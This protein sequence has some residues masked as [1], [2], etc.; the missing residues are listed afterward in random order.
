[1]KITKAKTKHPNANRKVLKQH[2]FRDPRRTKKRKA[3]GL[4]TIEPQLQAD[5][6]TRRERFERELKLRER[7]LSPLG[8]LMS[9]SSREAIDQLRKLEETSRSKI[10]IFDTFAKGFTP[11]M[12]PLAFWTQPGST[13]VYPPLDD[14]WTYRQ[15]NAGTTA[16][17][18]SGYIWTSV[19]AGYGNSQYAAAGILLWIIP[20]SAANTII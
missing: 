2:L 12:Q 14:Q 4:K 16:S 17:K 13:W 10:Q 11:P 6:K 15:G 9:Q 19:A 3:D 20:Q 5:F 1:M 7:M 18:K 8:D